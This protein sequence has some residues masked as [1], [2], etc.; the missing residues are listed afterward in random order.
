[1]KILKF[2]P[3]TG[4]PKDGNA[5]WR[6]IESSGMSV[7][8][9]GWS[10]MTIQDLLKMGY[11]IASVTLQEL[12][13]QAPVTPKQV[14]ERVHEMGWE[15]FCPF[16]IYL[17]QNPGWVS[18]LLGFNEYNF[19]NVLTRD[20]VNPEWPHNWKPENLVIIF[21]KKTSEPMA[22]PAGSEVVTA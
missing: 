5:I 22:T 16:N 20:Q 14:Q 12:R 7:G 15:F 10:S 21:H 4:E 18:V 1:M 8:S 11:E 19:P 2:A 6:A 17:N 9:N 3:L 13:L